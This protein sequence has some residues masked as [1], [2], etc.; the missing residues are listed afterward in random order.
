MGEEVQAAVGDEVPGDDPAFR[1][2]VETEVANTNDELGRSMAA[3]PDA[4]SLPVASS[5]DDAAEEAE[6]KRNAPEF[7]RLRKLN[8]QI[9]AIYGARGPV[10]A[11]T[12]EPESA[13]ET[14]FESLA[15]QT[16]EAE[17]TRS[18]QPRVD[19]G[20]SRTPTAQSEVPWIS[21]PAPFAEPRRKSADSNPIRRPPPRPE[22]KSADSN[23][24]RRPP[25]DRSGNLQTRTHFRRG[26][27][28]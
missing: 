23:P 15:P 18:E 16:G 22:R 3:E 4:G 19:R 1:T 8:R 27:R 9:E 2:P 14:G 5:V 20:E 10:E 26:G 12:S 17:A 25:P 13:E 28:C 7:A 24:I 21:R 11:S 6:L